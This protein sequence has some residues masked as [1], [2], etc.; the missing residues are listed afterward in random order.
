MKKTVYLSAFLALTLA[1]LFAACRN[2]SGG[3]DLDPGTNYVTVAYDLGDG[4]APGDFQRN[5]SVEKGV[6][7]Q[8]PGGDGFKRD[9][10]GSSYP[11]TGW[12]KNNTGPLLLA[13][14]KVTIDDNT[15][16]NAVWARPPYYFVRFHENGGEIVPGSV[17]EFILKIDPPDTVKFPTFGSMFTAP[18]NYG[19]R[20][21]S[22][23]EGSDGGKAYDDSDVFTVPA[24]AQH[25]DRL[26]LYARW[27]LL[28]RISFNLNGASGAQPATIQALPGVSV[29]LPDGTG[30]SRED[31][32]FIGWSADKNAVVPQ[33]PA[34][35]MV[36]I[37]DDQQTE[38][39]A[40]W[41]SN[42]NIPPNN[43][44]PPESHEKPD[45]STFV[46]V[47]LN[48]GT[49][50]SGSSIQLMPVP[51]GTPITLPSAG[52][53]REGHY[54]AG[55]L[56]DL[57]SEVLLGTPFTVSENVTLYAYW[58]SDNQRGTHMVTLRSNDGSGNE[59]I[60]RV[61]T[62]VSIE[63]PSGGFT[64]QWHKLEGWSIG[65]ETP[66][67]VNAGYTYQAGGALA[68]SENTTLDAVWSRLQHTVT[69][70]HSSGSGTGG[71]LPPQQTRF[72]G[73]SI[74]LPDAPDATRTG[75]IFDGWNTAQDGLSGD[76][77]AA[78]APFLVLGNV[79]LYTAWIPE[80]AQRVIVHFNNNGGAGVIPSIENRY[81]GSTIPLPRDSSQFARL[82]HEFIGWSREPS[83]PVLTTQAENAPYTFGASYTIPADAVGEIT[84]YA[85]WYR[86]NFSVNFV[87]NS[88]TPATIGTESI[89]RGASTV[90]PSIS[91]SG[92]IFRGWD[93]LENG[94]GSRYAVG[95]PF[96]VFAQTTLYAIWERIPE[97]GIAPATYTVT[98]YP[99][100]GT[101]GE[102]IALTVQAD[103]EITLPQSGFTRNDHRFVGW[104]DAPDSGHIRPALSLLRVTASINLHAA[105]QYVGTDPETELP[106]EP[107]LYTVTLR[108]NGGFGSPI[109][110]MPVPAGTVLIPT[111]G[112][113]W[114]GHDFAGWATS[115]LDVNVA[116]HYPAVNGIPINSDMTLYAV[117][118]VATVTVTFNTN[119][120]YW[121]DSQA[122]DS[123]DRTDFDSAHFA[124]LPT[125]DVGSVKGRNWYIPARDGYVFLGWYF[126]N[127]TSAN[128]SNFNLG[129]DTLP[130]YWTFDDMLPGSGTM[131]ARWMETS[132]TSA[133]VSYNSGID[134]MWSR[135]PTESGFWYREV[136]GT[137][138]NGEMNAVPGGVLNIPPLSEVFSLST[139]DDQLLD[140]NGL[141]GNIE[142]VHG[143]KL[144]SWVLTRSAGNVTGHANTRWFVHTINTRATVTA[145]DTV[146]TRLY[147][148]SRNNDATYTT[149][150]ILGNTHFGTQ[151]AGAATFV[152]QPSVKFEINMNIPIVRWRGTVESVYFG[153]DSAQ[154]PTGAD[155]YN[156]TQ[157]NNRRLL[158]T[159][160]LG[161]VE[162]VVT[163]NI[164]YM[165]NFPDGTTDPN[166]MT[167]AA[168]GWVSGD[169]GGS[170]PSGTPSFSQDIR[171]SGHATVRPRRF[172]RLE[173]V[174]NVTHI[175]NEQTPSST[176]FIFRADNGVYYWMQG[177]TIM[178]NNTTG[179]EVVQFINTTPG[180]GR[181]RIRVPA[182]T[183]GAQWMRA[184]DS[185]ISGLTSENYNPGIITLITT[186]INGNAPIM[187]GTENL[188]TFTV[189]AVQGSDLQTAGT[190][191]GAMLTHVDTDYR[192]TFNEAFFRYV[193]RYRIAGTTS[194]QNANSATV[195]ISQRAISANSVEVEFELKR[196]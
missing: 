191:E 129:T 112:F 35:S 47:T 38:L 8:L 163:Q 177:E 1:L 104:Q 57:G 85:V 117:W 109:Q 110:L 141:N 90:L 157:L 45:P 139:G 171:M 190:G 137:W 192:F 98:L 74:N 14:N 21:W 51:K 68:V 59:I 164:P 172:L 26:D 96:Q 126:G 30:F 15:T 42:A 84:F 116:A 131:Y 151:Y 180:S 143:V 10:D 114:Q 44:L 133:S 161:T 40:V 7:V 140:T 118:S 46:T 150:N 188:G 36:A 20:F 148:T 146:G 149:A 88:G 170:I 113:E 19:F 132:Q 3:A 193:S 79:T 25:N 52:F 24:G 62:G 166:N 58:R 152:D 95:A 13:G 39:F 196:P 31:F 77:V 54:I 48:S 53:T 63:L 27:Q 73:E 65:S 167:T 60:F 189:Q 124:S 115:A 102:P 174:T 158:L 105:W 4:T 28:H 175:F 142:D 91:R 9:Q 136:E 165:V 155:A 32:T 56:R 168:G 195:R 93:T 69:F 89:A 130:G 145:T 78:E 162:P 76:N 179:E 18:V 123:R 86:P 107:T 119:G 147:I 5:L 184:A 33:H 156:A 173:F 70:A 111:A 159:A 37:P 34:L 178:N 80:G 194:W 71:T 154:R 185:N 138:V 83:N 81:Q 128:N 16:F 64:R 106:K 127:I 99:N 176:N 49:G 29:K 169:A 108:P 41:F 82:H 181:I 67:D 66:P 135:S 43:M 72:F 122:Q 6:E 144:G 153:G 101:P 87:T 120:G 12:Q 183:P 61:P 17:T 2:P 160:P 121:P 97:G 100:S 125:S 182:G 103:T 92:Y 23:T 55:W 75:F 187:L 22:I 94:W 11:L 134:S 50:G 186:P